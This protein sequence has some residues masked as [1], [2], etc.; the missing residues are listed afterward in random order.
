[1]TSR[2]DDKETVPGDQDAKESKTIASV[3]IEWNDRME[4]RVEAPSLDMGIANTAV[5]KTRCQKCWGEQLGEEIV[6][7]SVQGS[8]VRCVGNDLKERQL[9]RKRNGY[10]RS[11]CGIL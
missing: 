11:L 9:Q 3:Q 1:M 4:V 8:S 2:K 5:K 7:V 10:P 6:P